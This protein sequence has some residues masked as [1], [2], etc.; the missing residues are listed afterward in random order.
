MAFWNSPKT[1][2]LRKFQFYV[3]LGDSP[4]YDVKSVTLPSYEIQVEE[5]QLGNFM[6]KFPAIDTWTECSV[7]VVIPDTSTLKLWLETAAASGGHL[8]S[9]SPENSFGVKSKKG[10][11]KKIDI[12][13][14]DSAGEKKITWKLKNTIIKSVSYGDLDYSSDELL[15]VDFTIAYDWCDVEIN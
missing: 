14:T 15:E 4:L 5:Y 13:A 2:P 6:F 11:N 10:V 12:V 8:P 3:S 7:R 9:N 1:D